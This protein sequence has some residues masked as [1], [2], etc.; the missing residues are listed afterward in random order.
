MRLAHQLLSHSSHLPVASEKPPEP[1]LRL[2]KCLI[3]SFDEGDAVAL[4]SQAN[5][6]AIAKWMRNAFPHPYR[7][8]DAAKWISIATSASPLHDYAICRPDENTVIGGIG[9]KP[10]D[11]VHYRTM[12]I[13]YWLGE[14]HWCQGIATEAIS[15]FSEWTFE[16]FK[17]VLR[18]EA[19]VY[20]GNDS[21][22][23]AL[24]KAG[25]SFEA[26]NK[27]AIE[28]MGV[29][30]SVLIYCKFRHGY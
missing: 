21:S 2:R 15:A 28:K 1:I 16:Q 7:G 5:N 8:E 25:Y 14:E 12:Q 18:L 3:R 26:K 10:K 20:E 24:E 19:E 23:R 30:M 27:N 29:V 13:G 22:V 6:P 17:H 11:D 9:L 4:A